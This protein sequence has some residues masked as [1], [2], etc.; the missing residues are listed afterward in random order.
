MNQEKYR[1]LVSG[2]SGCCICA[3]VLRLILRIAASMYSIIIRLRNFFYNVGLF[4]THRTEAAV[5]SIGNITAGGTG[6]TPLVIRLTKYLAQNHRCAILTRGYKSKH[7]TDEPALFAKA[8]PN[9]KIIRNP[10]RVAAALEAVTTHNAEVIILDDGFQ[11]RRLDRDLDILT[12]DAILPFGYE[13]ILPAGLLREPLCAIKR[14]DAFVITRADQVSEDDLKQVKNKIIQQ[15]PDAV[16]AGAVHEPVCV[17]TKDDRTVKVEELADKNVFAFCGIGNPQAF[18]KTITELKANLVGS[19]IYNDHHHYT[20]SDLVEIYKK[21]ESVNAELILTT[22]KDWTKIDS[23]NL[24]AKP[25][26]FAYLS[27]QLKF[28]SG[29][30]KLKQLIQRAFA[31]KIPQN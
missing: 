8:C 27:I 11:H 26:L 6:K 14:A 28:T 9:V 30:D 16:I 25:P 23:L 19:K 7:D 13:K 18:F 5:I 10:D 12:I 4:K 1:Q 20:D 15:K 22:E 3:A 21:G 2:Q 24:P 29:E 17:K 31:G